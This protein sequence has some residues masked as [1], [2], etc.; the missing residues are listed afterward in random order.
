MDDT[1]LRFLRSIAAQL[2]VE[3]IAEVHLF[4]AIRQGGMESGVAVLALDPVHELAAVAA[5]EPSEAAADASS[6]Q[7]AGE[8]ATEE[9]AHPDV[10]EDAAS[11]YAEPDAAADRDAIVEVDVPID[12]E[13]EHAELPVSDPRPAPRRYTVYTA[14]YRHTLKGPDRGKWEVSVTEEADAPLL[15]VDAVVRG[16]QRRS[17]DVDEIVRLTGGEV[18]AMTTAATRE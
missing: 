10:A 15:T 14:R 5:A 1:R 2:E 18:V 4:P 11:P 16:V 6:E 9:P 7:P 8:S 17:G 12:A 13:A 3:R